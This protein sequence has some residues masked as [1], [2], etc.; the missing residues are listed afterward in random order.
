[1]I[2]N[3]K[4]FIPLHILLFVYSFCSVCSKLASNEE[5]LSFKFCLFYGISLLILGV[6]AILWQQILKKMSLTT[7]FINKSVTIIWGMLL[8]VIIFSEKINLNMVIGSIIVL[9]GIGLVVTSNE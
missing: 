2:N 8:G 6:Y 3:L 5:F 7:A 4:K 1:M 9:F